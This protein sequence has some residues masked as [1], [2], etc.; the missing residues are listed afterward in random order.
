VSAGFG[1]DGI[2]DRGGLTARGVAGKNYEWRGQ[3]SPPDGGR[4][5]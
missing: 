1:R 4:P 2:A 3:A 5:H